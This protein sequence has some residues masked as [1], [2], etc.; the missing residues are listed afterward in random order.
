LWG[1]L[2]IDANGE[3]QPM[4]NPNTRSSNIHTEELEK[5]AQYDLESHQKL[6]GCLNEDNIV[7]HDDYKKLPVPETVTLEACP[8]CGAAPEL[9][10]YSTAKDMPL[11]RIVMCSN[12][13]AFGP[14]S[15]ALV[16]TGC[17]LYMPPEAFYKDTIK[18]AIKYWNSYAT[19]LVALRN[20]RATHTPSTGD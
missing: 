17:L 1:Q 4:L 16:Q 19:A 8:V 18:D 11:T 15:T 2:Y 13:E 6:P 10:Q 5:F 20:N 14:Q 12:G 7:V 3:I 9:Y